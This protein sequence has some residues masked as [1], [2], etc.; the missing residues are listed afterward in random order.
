MPPKNNK[1]NEQPKKQEI[2][3]PQNAQPQAANDADMINF[4]AYEK[5]QLEYE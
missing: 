4:E 5:E 2:N 3:T 1:A